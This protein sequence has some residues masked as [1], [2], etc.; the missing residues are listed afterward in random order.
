MKGTVTYQ[1]I[2]GGFWGIRGDDNVE[3]LPV[4]GLPSDVR[5][6]GTRISFEPEAASGI[7]LMMW[8]RPVN[9]RSVKAITPNRGEQLQNDLTQ[10]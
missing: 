9:V 6:D 4:N 1:N 7:S 10:S 5:R 3:Y 2:E 8:G